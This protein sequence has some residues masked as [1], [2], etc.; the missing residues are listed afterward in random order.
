MPES[1][2]VFTRGVNSV[3][4][5]SFSVASLINPFQFVWRREGCFRSSAAPFASPAPSSYLTETGGCQEKCLRVR[6]A[7][8]W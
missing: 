3:L 5:G 6:P 2:S 4:G 8:S 7:D 1:N